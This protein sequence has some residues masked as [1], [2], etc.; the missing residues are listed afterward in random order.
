MLIGLCRIQLHLPGNSS[1]KE[2]RSRLKP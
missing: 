1:L 2:K